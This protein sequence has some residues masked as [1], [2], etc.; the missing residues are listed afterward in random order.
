MKKVVE[1]LEIW[2]KE[3]Q[4]AKS[5]EKAK[6]LVS[7]KFHKWIYVF[8]KNASKRMLTKKVWDYI[9]KI[10]GEFVLRKKKVYSLSR[11]KKREVWE[12]IKE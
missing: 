5:E 3:E 7:Q 8:G 11:E 2:D 4:I 1:K 9:I 10:K 6:K 12:F